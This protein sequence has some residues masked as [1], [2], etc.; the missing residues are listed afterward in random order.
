[1]NTKLFISATLIFFSVTNGRA[2]DFLLKPG[3]LV[4]RASYFAASANNVFA[5]DGTSS[6]IVPGLDDYPYAERSFVGFAQY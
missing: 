5:S 6:P 1:M 2:D 4:A 3:T